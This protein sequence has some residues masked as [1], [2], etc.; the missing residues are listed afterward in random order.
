MRS[1]QRRSRAN[2]PQWTHVLHLT[3][4]FW[5]DQCSPTFSCH[6]LGG[7]DPT[8]CFRSGQAENQ[9][10]LTLGI[11]SGMWPPSRPWDIGWSL[12]KC[13]FTTHTLSSPSNADQPGVAR[14]HASHLDVNVFWD[15]TNTQGSRTVS[16]RERWIRTSLELL[17]P[18]VPPL[19]QEPRDPSSDFNPSA[20][21]SVTHYLVS[22]KTHLGIFIL[23]PYVSVGTGHSAR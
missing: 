14:P 11:G 18:A 13:E 9:I 22:P 23:S 1:Q 10:L 4:T 5:G 20:V 7:A 2:S 15:D 21:V 16:R 6:G 8:H 3:R 19:I 12:G 17:D